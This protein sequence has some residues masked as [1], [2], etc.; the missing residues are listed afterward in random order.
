MDMLGDAVQG[1]FWKANNIH[2][3]LRPK[4]IPHSVFKRCWFSSSK[5]FGI[6]PEGKDQVFCF[7]GKEL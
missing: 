4:P 1:S 5:M 3:P 6:Y 7:L 2:K